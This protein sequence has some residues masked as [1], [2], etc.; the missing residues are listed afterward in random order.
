MTPRQRP[1]RP[2]IEGRLSLAIACF[3]NNPS[4]KKRTLASA[5]N[6]T[7]ST[8]RSRLKGT[9]PRLETAP[10]NRKLSSI[11]E[12]SLI[13]WILNLDQRGF[14][15]QV[16]DVRRM[17]DALLA[18]RG[19]TPPPPPVGQ[20]WVSR[21][22][23]RQP[24]LQTKWN[25]KF[26]SQ[27][28]KGE[29]PV[30][31]NAW[32][33]LVQD[34]RHAYGILDQDVYN[35]DETGF[36]NGVASKLKVV[37]SSD[38]IGRATVIQPGNREWVTAIE[39][40]NASGWSLPPFVILSGKLHQASWYKGLPP[41]WTVAVSDNGWTNDG[42]GLE[43]VK[44]FNK[45]TESRTTGV[46]RLLILDGHSSH[47]TPEFDQFC[48]EQKIITLCMPAHTTHLLQPLDV[49]CFSPLKVLYGHEVAGLARRS[50]FHVDKLD[51]LWIYQRIR[52]NALSERN[53][54]ASFQ[55]T[56]LIPFYPERVLNN[57]TVVRTPSPPETIVDGLAS[58]TAETP[59]TTDQLQHQAHLIRHLLSR[60]SQSPTSLA[61]SQLVK[62]CQLAMQSATILVEDNQKLRASSQRQRQKRQTRRQ[63]IAHRGALQAQEGQRLVTEAESGVP[64]CDQPEPSQARTRTPPTCSRCHVQG[65]NRR[66][67]KAV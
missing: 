35:F 60:Q 22:I 54:K 57:L 51:F 2:S 47:A 26:H 40:I 63:Y 27:R 1:V 52:S 33:K 6:A 31:I 45:Q 15:P 62:G 14:P 65:H 24:E 20:N 25:R 3:N 59:R 55:A 9:T 50:I 17:A 56:G 66:Q 48:T 41:D 32:F 37:T 44:H 46:Y 53:I 29:D 42:L 43:W 16:I 7:E 36:M 10:V 34:T 21:F 38:T 18:G 19:Q 4:Q 11:E 13:Q 12:Q 39:C 49:G 61:I 64:G 30:K 28:A 67:C 23:S 5:Y 8:L 58:W